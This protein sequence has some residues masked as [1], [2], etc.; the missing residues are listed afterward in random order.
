MQIDKH[1]IIEINSEETL[2]KL[3]DA[4][5]KDLKVS[6]DVET[7]GLTYA[8]RPFMQTVYAAEIGFVIDK[9][10]VNK[11][12]WD[13]TATTI[14]SCSSLI[15][16]N[17][18]F[19]LIM[20]RTEW[21]LRF[22][23]RAHCTKIQSFLLDENGSHRLKDLC[24]KQ[25]PGSNKLETE[26]KDWLK[27][28]ND[29][30][31]NY[32][33]VPFDIMSH[34]AVQDTF[35]TRHLHDYQLPLVEAEFKDLYETECELIKVLVDMKVTGVR[36]DIPYLKNLV[37]NFTNKLAGLEIEIHKQ[38]GS[39]F[40]VSS[41]LEL[42]DVLY[43]KLGLKT[44]V[45]TEKGEL[46]T[47]KEALLGLEHPIGKLLIE[48]RSLATSLHTFVLPWLDYADK[49]GYLHPNINQ[50]GA[51][52]GRFSSSDPNCQ[53]IPKRS[54]QSKVLRRVFIYPDDMIGG[55]HDQRQME[56]I[57]FAHYSGDPL[58][59]KTIRE[60]G[61]LHKMTATEVF[62]VPQNEV[63]SDQRRLGKGTN[64]SV[65]YGCGK[66]KLG[67]FLSQDAYAG[68][69]V[70]SEEALDII[71]K[72][73]QRFPQV[74]GFTWQ[75]INRIRQRADFSV[76]NMFGRK[77]RLS[78]D[79]AYVGV[80][81]LIQSWAADCM[82]QGMVKAWKY[83]QGTDLRLYLNIH[84]EL[85]WYSTDKYF[86]DHARRLNTCLT[87]FANFSLPIKTEITKS[88]TNWAD[89]EEITI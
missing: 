27:T 47:A 7:T 45:Y 77:C 19:D 5:C 29:S 78:Y 57:G 16:A 8:D 65:I 52:S 87:Q 53:N 69:Y 68:R 23:G 63:T 60:G 33:K 32:D 85:K 10:R 9:R 35:L 3:K 39:T 61:D 72:Y 37:P 59:Q 20:A 83:A 26:V 66:A 82:K 22:K 75:V 46:S 67:S 48:H 49:Y 40:N 41:D 34:Y 76:K 25:W 79:K 51:R 64:F 12:L 86:M 1:K 80:N 56:M 14:L 74:A 17:I 18:I 50:T 4:L 88:K 38:A 55:A 30:N 11:K 54:P 21:G 6:Y 58:M 42:T 36:L 84:D 28:H 44:K 24:E 70:S 89:E 43:R 31:M 13:D 2:T 62:K 81:R 73:K 71:T 15:G